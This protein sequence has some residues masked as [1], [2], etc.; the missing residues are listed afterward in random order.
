MFFLLF[1]GSIYA[2]LWGKLPT[3][4]DLLEINQSE[5][6]RILDANGKIIDKLYKFNRQS[7]SYPELAK[8]RF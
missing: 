8:Y 2:G 5:A 3:Q 1:F 7:I 4:K 6:S